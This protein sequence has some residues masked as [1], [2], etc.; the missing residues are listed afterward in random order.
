MSPFSKVWLAMV[1]LLSYFFLGQA[2]CQTLTSQEDITYMRSD[3]VRMRRD[4]EEIK[5]NLNAP[6]SAANQDILR[7]QAAQREALLELH[8]G[9]Q[10]LESQTEETSYQ[11]ESIKQEVTNLK[12]NMVSQMEALRAANKTAAAQQRP[13]GDSA[14]L[15]APSLNEASAPAYS[16]PPS[17]QAPSSRLAAPPLAVPT[18]PAVP[19][20]QAPSPPGMPSVPSIPPLSG[21]P[22][23]SPGAGEVPSA[24]PA[25]VIDYTKLYDTAYEDYVRQSYSLARSEFEEYLRRFPES[26]LADNAQYWVGECY[27]AE[28]KYDQAADAFRKVID[29][30]PTGNKVPRAMLKAGYAYLQ[31]GRDSNA[32]EMFQQVVDAYPLSSEADQAKIKIRSLE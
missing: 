27:F 23:V 17:P 1:C 6:A 13:A 4:L 31:L 29:R 10:R 9:Q 16:A 28:G 20:P 18:V 24:S 32:K 5:K 7:N 3:L 25:D 11:L 12:L 8:E 2:G 30:Y 21:Q 19:S 22:A 26:D 14:F 15:G